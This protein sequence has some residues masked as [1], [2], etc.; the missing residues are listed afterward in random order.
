MRFDT[1]RAAVHEPNASS[2][3]NSSLALRFPVGARPLREISCHHNSHRVTLSHPHVCRSISPLPNVV[4]VASA[5]AGLFSVRNSRIYIRGRSLSGGRGSTSGRSS[6]GLGGSCTGKSGVDLGVGIRA[7]S[8]GFGVGGV[9]GSFGTKTP[10][11][12]KF[13]V[14]TVCALKCEKGQHCAALSSNG[15]G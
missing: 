13:G 14:G 6:G 15:S 11:S 8:A 2:S 7:G 1:K 10:P 4:G 5:D 3:D 9:I 12:T